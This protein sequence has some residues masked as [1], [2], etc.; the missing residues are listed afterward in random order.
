MTDIERSE[1]LQSTLLEA[2]RLSEDGED[3]E[4][5]NLLLAAETD[6]AEDPTLL[7]M[8][9]AIASGLGIEGMAVDYFSRCIDLNPTDV[10][11]LIV[12]GSGLAAAG[13]PAAEPALRL[14]A[15]TAPTNPAARSSYGTLLVRTGFL[16]QGMEELETARKLDP[17]DADIRR[18]LGIAY[19]LLGRSAESL[20]E[21][22]SAVEGDP[23]DPE[24]RLLWGLTL[25]ASQ[26][27]SDAAEALYPLGEAMPQDGTVQMI[28]AL[29]F[30]L[31]GWEEEAWVA[32]S[33]AESAEPPV[34]AGSLR[35]VEDAIAGED[36]AA[37]AMLF[38]EL[39]PMAL[40]QR[41]FAD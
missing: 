32:F 17:D 25:L 4:A 28:L 8:I 7:C 39:A 13:D 16:E 15:L 26:E 10:E 22:E 34:D 18:S 36:E 1:A 5:L 14:A 38:D 19:H 24:I 9:G 12:A 41:I 20:D 40:R 21:L 23:E 37:Q 27:V 29:T 6:N 11:V 2:D 35:E 31:E 30:R 3:G 33:R